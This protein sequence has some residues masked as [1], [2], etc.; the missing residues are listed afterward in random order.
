MKL[1]SV[2]KLSGGTLFSSRAC[3]FQKR[4]KYI[5]SLAASEEIRKFRNKA[6]NH[7][8]WRPIC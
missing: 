3:E 8:N 2:K 7:I 5:S 1:P 4:I 6:P